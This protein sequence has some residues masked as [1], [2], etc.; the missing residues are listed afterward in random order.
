M[1]PRRLKPLDF[2]DDLLP[3]DDEIA[4]L[5]EEFILEATSAEHTAEERDDDAPG[6][7]IVERLLREVPDE[8]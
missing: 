7:A 1:E 3:D 5:A 8:S 4:E 6:E 2:R